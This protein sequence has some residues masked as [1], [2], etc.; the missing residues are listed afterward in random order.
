[1]SIGAVSLGNPVAQAD[2]ASRSVSVAH[3]LG[4]DA[5]TQAVTPADATRLRELAASRNERGAEQAAAVEAQATADRN[6]VEAARPRAVLP[7]GGARLTS[8]F[9]MR[10]GTLH[11]GIDLA[12]PIGTPEYAA[13]DGVV[14]KAGPA[15]GLVSP[16][17]SSTPT[18]T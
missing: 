11:A 2:T 13:A 15:S 8:T 10:W 3:Q 12:A 9:G 5:G 17:T 16:S 7:V 1:V 14:L 6:A 18:A 4:I